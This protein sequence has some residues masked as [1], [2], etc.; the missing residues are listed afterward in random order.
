MA[1][2]WGRPPSN[3][4]GRGAIRPAGSESVASSHTGSAMRREKSAKTAVLRGL[5]CTGGRSASGGPE[6]RANV[7]GDDRSPAVVIV[8]AAAIADVR[9]PGRGRRDMFAGTCSRGDGARGPGRRSG[10]R[11]RRRTTQTSIR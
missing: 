8:R 7:A 4:C 1:R 3:F 2:R 6:W 11:W 10:A 5:R 9:R